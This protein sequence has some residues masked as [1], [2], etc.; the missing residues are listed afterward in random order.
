[1]TGQGGSVLSFFWGLDDTSRSKIPEEK[2]I[3]SIGINYGGYGSMGHKTTINQFVGSGTP[4][5]ATV[6]VKNPPYS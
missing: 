1:M 3:Y 2:G 5:T 6:Q 4:A